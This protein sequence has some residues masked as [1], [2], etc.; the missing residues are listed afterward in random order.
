MPPHVGD[1]QLGAGRRKE[2]SELAE[3]GIWDNIPPKEIISADSVIC[4]LPWDTVLQ[5]INSKL[6]K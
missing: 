2:L 1:V 6:T 3:G 4:A 5:F